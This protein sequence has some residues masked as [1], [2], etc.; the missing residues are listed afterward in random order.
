MQGAPMCGSI[1]TECHATGYNQPAQA[2]LR[3]K[4][5]RGL[6]TPRSAFST[7]DNRYLWFTQQRQITADVK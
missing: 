1:D 6:G 7:T 5:K 3:S 4:I 2:K